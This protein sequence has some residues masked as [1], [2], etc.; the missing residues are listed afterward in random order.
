MNAARRSI[1]G[2]QLQILHQTT[3]MLARNASQPLVHGSFKGMTLQTGSAMRT[4]SFG[5]MV[6]VSLKTM[7]LI[8]VSDIDGFRQRDAAKPS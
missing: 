6:V 1:N 2:S 8:D 5:S 7:Y 4:L 3:S